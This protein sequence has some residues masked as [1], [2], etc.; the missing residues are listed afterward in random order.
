IV[1]SALVYIARHTEIWQTW[2]N[3]VFA[4][5]QS[6]GNATNASS[7]AWAWGW[8]QVVFWSFPQMALGL[9]GFE[10]IMN[11]VPRVTGGLNEQSGTHA[12]RVRNT[13]KLMVTAASIMAVYL[14]SAVLVTTLLVPKSQ[15]KPEGAATHRAL[16]YLAHGSPLA[17]GTAGS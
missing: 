15:M 8:V 10:M 4:A 11:V 3:V 14:V 17:D 6:V 12:G 16:A 1:I 13:R 9:S 5:P 7:N 2:S